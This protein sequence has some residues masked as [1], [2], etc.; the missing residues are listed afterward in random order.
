MRGMRR[1][2]RRGVG[3]EGGGGERS[4]RVDQRRGK[5][6]GVVV[7]FVWLVVLGLC[8]CTFCPF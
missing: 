3:E 2:G 7:F 1:E 6:L 5:D 4:F 8:V